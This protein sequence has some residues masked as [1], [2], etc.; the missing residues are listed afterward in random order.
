[1]PTCRL[2]SEDTAGNLVLRLGIFL[3]AA[4]WG[5]AD[6]QFLLQGI[7]VAGPQDILCQIVAVPEE[8]FRSTA[9]FVHQAS[10]V[11]PDSPEVVWGLAD[12]DRPDRLVVRQGSFPVGVCLGLAV[13]CPSELVLGSSPARP[14]PGSSR[15]ALGS[16]GLS[17]FLGSLLVQ[18]FGSVAVEVGPSVLVDKE[19]SGAAEADSGIA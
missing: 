1:M 5:F 16:R 6:T 19:D 18:V 9:G 17:G 4:V 13:C 10:F 3:L 14:F 11:G 15:L 7:F 8:P 2:L 12:I